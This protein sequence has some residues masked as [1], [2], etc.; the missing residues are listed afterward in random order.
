MVRDSCK[1]IRVCLEMLVGGKFPFTVVVPV[2]LRDRWWVGCDHHDVGCSRRCD[3]IG[4][5]GQG[6][7][8]C[9]WQ[10]LLHCC[11]QVEG[12]RSITGNSTVRWQANVQLG[13]CS[14]MQ[15]ANVAKDDQQRTDNT[16]RGVRGVC[17]E[18]EAKGARER[19]KWLPRGTFGFMSVLPWPSPACPVT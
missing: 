3:H 4:G 7:V 16:I 14:L 11:R 2:Q 1:G 9:G 18:M 12:V 5:L 17:H 15:Q 8:A 13:P 19:V 10:G 6:G